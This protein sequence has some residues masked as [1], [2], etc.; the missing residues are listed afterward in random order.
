MTPRAG[1]FV[2]DDVCVVCV[3]CGLNRLQRFDWLRLST[4]AVSCRRPE[5]IV[6]SL[7]QKT[8]GDDAESHWILFR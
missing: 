2:F 7:T 4:E 1:G 8:P 6:R 3:F 5:S